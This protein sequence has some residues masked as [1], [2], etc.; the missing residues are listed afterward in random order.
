MFSSRMWPILSITELE[1][2]TVVKKVMFSK[3]INNVVYWFA[4]ILGDNGTT[5]VC[6]VPITGIYRLLSL[7]YREGEH[8]LKNFMMPSHIK[9]VQNELG[10]STDDATAMLARF[11]IKFL[12]NENC[13]AFRY[14]LLQSLWNHMLH[15]KP[16]SNWRISQYSRAVRKERWS[17]GGVTNNSWRRG[18]WSPWSEKDYLPKLWWEFDV[19]YP[20]RGKVFSRFCGSNSSDERETRQDEALAKNCPRPSWRGCGFIGWIIKS[21]KVIIDI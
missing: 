8:V 12:P 9:I 16:N 20:W 4:A 7:I 17:S 1:D 18:G 13:V 6:L 5:T 3:L 19:K 21:R 14:I 15:L 2:G 10:I 11:G